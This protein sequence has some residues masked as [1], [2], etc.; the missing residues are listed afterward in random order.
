MS[1]ER[2]IVY[3]DISSLIV[4]P[5]TNYAVVTTHCDVK[6]NFNKVSPTVEFKTKCG[7]LLQN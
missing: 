5:V 4:L 2:S 6:K 7:A 1:S 3:S